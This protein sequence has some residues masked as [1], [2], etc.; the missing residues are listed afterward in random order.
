[1]CLFAHSCEWLPGIGRGR[2]LISQGYLGSHYHG[3]IPPL[4]I[5][6]ILILTKGGHT[7]G[8]A[9]W[10]PQSGHQLLW[11]CMLRYGLWTGWGLRGHLT[12]VMDDRASGITWGPS[13]HNK[14]ALQNSTEP[15]D[16]SLVM[17]SQK[18]LNFTTPHATVWENVLSWPEWS[19]KV[20]GL[21]VGLRQSP[22]E[23]RCVALC[24]SR[25]RSLIHEIME[26]LKQTPS[27]SPGTFL[28]RNQVIPVKVT[29]SSRNKVTDGLK[30]QSRPLN[31]AKDRADLFQSRSSTSLKAAIIKSQGGK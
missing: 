14:G 4:F 2:P 28:F 9:I 17:W 21:K 29:V 5:S 7:W 11:I 1:M 20:S 24:T 22:C 13:R 16:D 6:P 27:Q 15:N 10:F 31:P 19:E 12:A 30:H 23:P 3:G 18:N 8:G 26:V 25:R